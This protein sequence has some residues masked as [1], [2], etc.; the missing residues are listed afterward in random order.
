MKVKWTGASMPTFE[1]D[2][3][4]LAIIVLAMREF[5]KSE[6]GSQ[7]AV[8]TLRTFSA[9]DEAIRAMREADQS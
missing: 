5:F 8:Q 9:I 1:L 3:E 6:N 7:K 4:E 2:F